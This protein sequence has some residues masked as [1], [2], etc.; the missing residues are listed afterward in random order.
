VVLHAKDS[1]AISE[2]YIH[3]IIISPSACAVHEGQRGTSSIVLL[4]FGGLP[5]NLCE[6][7]L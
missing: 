1:L 3:S 4:T 7:Y 5:K 6:L 2:D